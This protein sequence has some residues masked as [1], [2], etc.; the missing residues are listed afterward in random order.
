VCR[1]VTNRS[2]QPCVLIREEDNAFEE[3]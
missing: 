3:G 2:E 1:T